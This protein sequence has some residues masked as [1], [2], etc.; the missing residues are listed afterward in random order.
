MNSVRQFAI[1]EG[2][3][4]AAAAALAAAAAAAALA[5]GVLEYE[6]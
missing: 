2:Q 4:S 1:A 6:D 3:A 5:E